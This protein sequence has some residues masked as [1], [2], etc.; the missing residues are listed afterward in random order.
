MN[1]FQQMVQLLD[2]AQQ[3]L[4]NMPMADTAQSET[5]I[6]RAVFKIREAKSLLLKKEGEKMLILVT[7]EEEDSEPHKVQ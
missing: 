2:D 4:E 1:N 5:N 6:C 7:T 3:A